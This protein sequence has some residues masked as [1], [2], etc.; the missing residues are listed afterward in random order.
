MQL[1]SVQ[2]AMQLSDS[3]RRK[4]ATPSSASMLASYPLGFDGRVSRAAWKYDMASSN[5]PSNMWSSPIQSW[6]CATCAASRS[7]LGRP[8][9][10]SFSWNRAI[11]R[12]PAPYAPR[13]PGPAT[14]GRFRPLRTRRRGRSRCRRSSRRN[15]AEPSLAAAR[16][17]SGLGLGGT[18][19][20]DAS[21]SNRLGLRPV[22]AATPPR[23]AIT[24][25][26]SAQSSRKVLT[27]LRRMNLTPEEKDQDQAARVAEAG[28]RKPSRSGEH[29]LAI[30]PPTA[31]GATPDSRSSPR[32]AIAAL[33][34]YPGRGVPRPGHTRENRL[35]Q[36]LGLGRASC[37]RLP[38]PVYW[39]RRLRRQP[40]KTGSRVVSP[41]NSIPP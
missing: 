22:S 27:I 38:G 10:D 18:P 24:I 25:R 13:P 1:A 5:R 23:L 14:R 32:L 21:S 12:A 26:A 17:G 34:L 33:V 39:S 30:L 6:N 20:A 3:P 36:R 11:P 19:L 8:S 16:S 41:S 28:V 31:C 35:R 2:Q 7:D 29:D 37:N 15:R 40:E 9:C 4:A